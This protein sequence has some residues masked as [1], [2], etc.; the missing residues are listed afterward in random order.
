MAAQE[1]DAW[2]GTWN[3]KLAYSIYELSA[4]P[5][6]EVVRFERSGEGWKISTDV[7]YVD[8]SWMH[9]YGIFKFDG[10]AAPVGPDMFT[11][12]AFTR[13][14]DHTYDLVEKLRGRL[15]SITRTVISADGTTRTSTTVGTNEQGRTVQNVAIYERWQAPIAARSGWHVQP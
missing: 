3:L 5:K 13:I 10:L 9:R 1:A 2:A 6:S 14:D 4:A 12:W 8:G 15:I 11:T 7:N